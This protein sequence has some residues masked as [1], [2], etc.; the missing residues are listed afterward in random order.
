M[1]RLQAHGTQ[2]HAFFVVRDAQ[3]AQL[4]GRFVQVPL[5]QGFSRVRKE[6]QSVDQILCLV[7][8]LIDSAALRNLLR[9]EY[10]SNY[11]S[12]YIFKKKFDQLSESMTNL[13]AEVDGHPLQA[14]YLRHETT[15]GCLAGIVLPLHNRRGQLL[16]YNRGSSGNRI[17]LEV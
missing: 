17:N 4:L 8:Q 13:Q 14:V 7:Q 1:A 6:F 2:D 5:H 10:K 16:K 11:Y 12:H 15:E 9:I 3:T